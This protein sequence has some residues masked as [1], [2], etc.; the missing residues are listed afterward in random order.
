[1]PPSARDARPCRRARGTRDHAAE[2]AGRS[3]PKMAAPAALLAL[4]GAW[5][6]LGSH[7]NWPHGVLTMLALA[8]G[9]TALML[10]VKGEEAR[11]AL[12][13]PASAGTTP[14]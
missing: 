4:I 2:R 9:W 11:P 12:S 3:P 7:I 5:S 8:G 10:A 13:P 6:F 14:G 1:M